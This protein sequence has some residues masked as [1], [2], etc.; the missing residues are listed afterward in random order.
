MKFLLAILILVL[1]NHSLA[2]GQVSNL[3]TPVSYFVNHTKQLND[4]K[5]NLNQYRQVSIVGTSGIGKT[6]LLRTYAYEHK[7]KYQLIWFIDC[8]LDLN[9]EWFLE[10]FKCIFEL[11]SNKITE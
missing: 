10:C 7:N 3:I 11:Y 8:N 1:H 5:R 4:V 6:Q 2:S 9:E